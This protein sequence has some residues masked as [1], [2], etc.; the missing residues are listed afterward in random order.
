M[1]NI[2]S[3]KI[4]N[5]NHLICTVRKKI[6]RETQLSFFLN[7][8]LEA[9]AIHIQFIMLVYDLVHNQ[10]VINLIVLIKAFKLML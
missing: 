10:L 7:S 9:L 5:L 1:Q 3:F 8:Y 6:S 2:F 4:R